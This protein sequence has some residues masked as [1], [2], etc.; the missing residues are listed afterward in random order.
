MPEHFKQQINMWQDNIQKV[1]AKELPETEPRLTF[2]KVMDAPK[3][4]PLLGSNQR[5]LFINTDKIQR[6]CEKHLNIGVEILQQIPYAI[7][8]PIAIFR[9]REIRHHNRSIVIMT[10]I[11][12][13]NGATVVVPITINYRLTALNYGINRIATVFAKLMKMALAVKI[14]G[15]LKRLKKAGCFILTVKKLPFGKDT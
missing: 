2:L 6:I 8:D 5:P 4:L 14:G 13:N 7:T 11:V 1:L 9:D 15:S 10:D 12:D 3:V